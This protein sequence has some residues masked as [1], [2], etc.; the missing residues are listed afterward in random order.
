M[1]SLAKK[2]KSK[3]IYEAYWQELY[4]LTEN[5]KSDLLFYQEDLYFS[6]NLINKYNQWISKKNIKNEFQEIEYSIFELI[7][8][9]NQLIDK[10]NHH[11][12][13]ISNNISTPY[14]NDS[15]GFRTIHDQMEIEFE[16]FIKMYRAS[17]LKVFSMSEE[18]IERKEFA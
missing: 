16:E 2:T 14:L 1:K 3:T 5:W 7:R 6:H 4:L 15:Y 11:L 8:N 13:K 10:T 18:V 12:S 9:C 17:R